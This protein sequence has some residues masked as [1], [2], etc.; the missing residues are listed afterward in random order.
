MSLSITTIKPINSNNYSNKSQPSF[1]SIAS[2]VTVKNAGAGNKVGRF[3]NNASTNIR[4]N[5]VFLLVGTLFD[6][7]LLTTKGFI[8]GFELGHYF[9]GAYVTHK[10]NSAKNFSASHY[11]LNVF[12]WVAD[13]IRAIGKSLKD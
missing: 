13:G 4:N 6:K 7:S 3:L 8:D 1:G 2:E 5:G 9:L 12:A 10:P 11:P